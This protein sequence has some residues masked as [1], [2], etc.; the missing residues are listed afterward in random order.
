MAAPTTILTIVKRFTYR[1]DANEEYS[2]TYALTGTTP[3]DSTA[4]RALFDALV[5]QE[6]TLYKGQVSVVGGYGYDHLTYDSGRKQWHTDDSVWG[7]D[8]T[9]APNSPVAG[10]YSG[11]AAWIRWGL[12]RL[13]GGKRIYLRKYFH[14]AYLDNANTNPDLLQDTWVTAAAAFGAFM[15]GGPLLGSRKITDALGTNTVGH[16]D[17]TYATTRTLKRRGKR[18]PTSGEP[19]RYSSD[20]HIDDLRRFL[21]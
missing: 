7:V 11:T 3:A 19:A 20:R 2:N 18:P 8:L 16:A 6:K 12:D 15:D 4:W 10:T 9:V 17:S 13:V 1:G 14:P 21:V 5:A